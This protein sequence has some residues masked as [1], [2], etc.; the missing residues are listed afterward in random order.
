[1]S[2]IKYSIEYPIKTSISILYKRLT[3]PS[4]LSEWFA[5]NVNIKNDVLTFYWDG[6]EE[7]AIVLK[8]KKHEFIRYQWLDDDEGEEERYFEFYIQVHNMTKDISLIVTDFAEDEQEKEDGMQLWDKQIDNL[9][10]AI[11]I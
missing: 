7:D 5:D 6:S 11:G 4:G 9:K 3:T 1:M 10:N 8:K 2:L